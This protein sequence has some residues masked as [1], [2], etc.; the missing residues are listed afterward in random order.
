MGGGSIDISLKDGNR[1]KQSANG[2]CLA[3]TYSAYPYNTKYS[4][5]V[6]IDDALYYSVT[7]DD[8]TYSGYSQMPEGST[9]KVCGWVR[10]NGKVTN[11]QCVTAGQF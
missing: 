1:V 8:G 7:S 2:A 5:D 6:Y 11:T 10:K 9:I 4:A 3:N